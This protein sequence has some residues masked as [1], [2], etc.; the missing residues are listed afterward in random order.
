M[1]TQ[2]NS[3]KCKGKPENLIKIITL[4]EICSKTSHKIQIQSISNILSSVYKFQLPLLHSVIDISHQRHK[5]IV[6]RE[7][8]LVNNF[9][10]NHDSLSHSINHDSILCF[11]FR[12]QGEIFLFIS[13]SV[14]TRK[15]H[16]YRISKYLLIIK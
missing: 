1:R 13:F 10:S 15:M 8:F 12:C 9:N 16:N 5:S 4:L 6:N 11:H 14:F 3:K 2:E 7:H